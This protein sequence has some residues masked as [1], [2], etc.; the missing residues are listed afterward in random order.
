MV[1]GRNHSSGRSHS[2]G[3]SRNPSPDSPDSIISNLNI[4]K[5]EQRSIQEPTESLALNTQE[6]EG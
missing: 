2:P 1:P 5:S 6:A 3:R 4:Q